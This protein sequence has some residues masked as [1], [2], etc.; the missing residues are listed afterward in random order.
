MGLTSWWRWK[1]SSVSSLSLTP[2]QLPCVPQ[3]KT[4][5][6]EKLSSFN[7]SQSLNY[8]HPKLLLCPRHVPPRRVLENLSIRS[9]KGSTQECQQPGHVR[10]SSVCHFSAIQLWLPCRCALPNT[11]QALCIQ[12][13][14]P[15][16]TEWR[17]VVMINTLTEMI[18]TDESGKSGW[19]L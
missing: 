6:T 2:W 18:K 9:Y 11:F 4:R 17:S 8:P 12:F 1:I 14:C 13:P 10:K 7:V 16:P 15:Q 19:C 3:T 5:S